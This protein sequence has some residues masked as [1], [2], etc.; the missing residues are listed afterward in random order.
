MVKVGDSIPSIQLVEKNPHDE[1]NIA[2]E[3]GSGNAV[4]IGVP[5]AFSELSLSCRRT[6]C[7][8]LVSSK[9][10]RRAAKS[11]KLGRLDEQLH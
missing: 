7:V 11:F 1:V 4:I 9:Q 3:I 10:E 2:T 6:Q 8:Q 5:A